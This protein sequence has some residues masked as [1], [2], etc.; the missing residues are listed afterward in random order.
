[1]L[2]S[3]M[4]E[5]FI[6]GAKLFHAAKPIDQQT[7]K[8]LDRFKE[9]HE[10]ELQEERQKTAAADA[11][12]SLATPTMLPSPESVTNT[13]S[14]NSTPTSRP[15]EVAGTAPAKQPEPPAALDRPR[16]VEE[17][18]PAHITLPVNW[19]FVRTRK[20]QSSGILLAASSMEQSQRLLT[21]PGMAKHFPRTFARMMYSTLGAHDEHEPD[22]E[23]EEGELFWPGQLITGGGMGWVCLMGKAMLK[24]FGRELGYQG[25]EGIIPKPT[26]EDV[27]S[28]Y[29]STPGFCPDPCDYPAPVQR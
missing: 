26:G 9:L 17:S 25:L 10:K 7:N 19:Y 14:A 18:V 5:A 22:I 23:D 29:A 2:N 4:I 3:Y 16:Q 24:E 13:N 12:S 21:L 27:S 8:M 20:S 28:M 15:A 1:M 11:P 6:H